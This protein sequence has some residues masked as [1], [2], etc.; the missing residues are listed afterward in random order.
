MHALSRF[1]SRD[2]RQSLFPPS[3]RLSPA[4]PP[5]CAVPPVVTCGMP[6]V[7]TF[8]GQVVTLAGV[9]AASDPSFTV[10]YIASGVPGLTA[11]CPASG[12]AQ[13]VRAVPIKSGVLICP[14]NGTVSFNL[15]SAPATACFCDTVLPRHSGLAALCGVPPDMRCVTDV[16]RR[17]QCSS[18]RS[19]VLPGPTTRVPSCHG[20][21]PEPYV[22]Q[23]R[24]GASAVWQVHCQ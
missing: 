19:P 5:L 10:V 18:P 16:R 11:T 9:C 13:L 4:P 24:G 1:P 21:V 14:D 7:C 22:Q 15:T 6:P 20:L 3:G 23:P 2:A 12:G 8:G 17:P